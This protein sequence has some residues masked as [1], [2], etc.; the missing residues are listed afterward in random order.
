MLPKKQLEKQPYTTPDTSTKCLL[1][2]PISW[3]L[4]ARFLISIIPKDSFNKKWKSSWTASW[5][6]HSQPL[7]REELIVELFH[8]LAASEEIARLYNA[9]T[10][11]NGCSSSGC[12]SEEKRPSVK[13]SFTKGLSLEIY[14]PFPKKRLVFFLK[15]SSIRSWCSCSNPLW[16][17]FFLQTF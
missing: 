13:Q 5:A 16:C 15:T 7:R 11:K 8:D 17:V 10:V 3:K 14:R 12:F 6:L 4:E 9:E 2:V 1:D